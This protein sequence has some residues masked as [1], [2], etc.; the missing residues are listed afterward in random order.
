[1]ELRDRLEGF[2][3]SLNIVQKIIFYIVC[4]HF[5]PYLLDVIFYLFKLEFKS[6]SIFSWFYITA[7]FSELIFKPW[8]IFTYGFFHNQS[9]F[10]HIFWNMLLFYYFGNIIYDLFGKKTLKKLFF[11]GIVVGGITYILSYNLFPVFSDV[12]SSMIGASAGISSI[13]FFLT[14]YNPNYKIRIFFFDFKLLYLA[15]FLFLF[16][17]IQIPY[18][19]AGGHIAHIGG[20]I[21]GYYFYRN[22]YKQNFIDYIFSFFETSKRVSQKTSKM[23]NKF[24]QNKIDSILDKISESGYDSLSKQEK[25]YLFKAGKKK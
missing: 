21:W 25:E 19:N 2:M 8:S 10:S 13:I 11:S 7:D 1:M 23:D 5:L 16:D 4:I 9:S 6:E 12:K 14:F 24:N 18:G 20:S 15:I 3:D 22:L 17:V